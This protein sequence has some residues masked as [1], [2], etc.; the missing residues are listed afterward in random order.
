MTEPLPKFFSTWL[1]A[2]WRARILSVPPASPIPL[3]ISI[4]AFLTLFFL[5]LLVYRHLSS[6]Y[7]SFTLPCVKG[8]MNNYC[9]FLKDSSP[10][11]FPHG[12]HFSRSSC[13]WRENQSKRHRVY[14]EDMTFA[15]LIVLYQSRLSVI[16][17]TTSPKRHFAVA[18][19]TPGTTL[20]KLSNTNP[21]FDKVQNWIVDPSNGRA[22]CRLPG[23]YYFQSPS[24]GRLNHGEVKAIY[25]RDESV[26]AIEQ[27]SKWEP[28]AITIVDTEAGRTKEIYAGL[29]SKLK[30]YVREHPSGFTK[31]E[32]GLSN[33]NSGLVYSASCTRLT[34]T[35]LKLDCNIYLAKAED[36]PNVHLEATYSIGGT[37]TALVTRLVG[38]KSGR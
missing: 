30:N 27:Q 3:S 21:S 11:T 12:S 24:F 32:L 29:R 6:I 18:W 34:N 17:G 35:L 33:A 25:T 5:C 10:P 38:I 2:I 13:N 20:E 26:A 9:S 28:V 22:I 1:S 7:I 16:E 36:R 8:F 15:M 19:N 14:N 31:R 37:K 23:H 4:A